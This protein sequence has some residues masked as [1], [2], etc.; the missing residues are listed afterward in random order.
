MSKIQ[1]WPN[2]RPSSFTFLLVLWALAFGAGPFAQNAL[3][4]SGGSPFN[5]VLR[6]GD[7]GSDV[8]TLQRWL[9]AVGIPT[10]AD[11]DFGPQTKASVQRFQRA[12]HLSPPSGTKLYT[13]P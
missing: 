1:V 9:T 8:K 4:S 3:A 7:R 13:H 6:Q 10:T 2:R 11:G 12:A 5:R